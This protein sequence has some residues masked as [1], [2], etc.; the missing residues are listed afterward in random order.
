M[1][2]GSQTSTVA[3]AVRVGTNNAESI[4]GDDGT[5]LIFGL[6]GSTSL[7]F[8][9]LARVTI[10]KS[11]QLYGNGGIDLICGG[12]GADYLDGGAGDDTLD[13]GRGDDVLVGGDGA[14]TLFGGAG[15]DRVT[16]EQA[17]SVE[18]FQP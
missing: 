12:N 14:N 16:G 5:D 6:A 3:I 1:S 13:G 8:G 9:S 17:T 15:N 18:Q 7:S 10:G 4:N 2:D 11:D